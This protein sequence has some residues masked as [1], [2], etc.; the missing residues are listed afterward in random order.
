MLTRTDITKGIYLR[1]TASRFGYPAG[2][3]GTV[4]ATGT[5]W[6]GNWY[7]QLRWL[8]RPTGKRNRPVSEWSLNLR[9]KDL[10][11]FEQIESWEQVQELLRELRPQRKSRR[12]ARRL[13]RFSNPLG[14]VPSG[15]RHPNQLK[16][17]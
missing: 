4:H 1:L 14:R 17:Y 8:N 7:F 12:K 16:L 3:I 10:E 9:D 13:P 15:K 5:D 6:S 2:L 11:D